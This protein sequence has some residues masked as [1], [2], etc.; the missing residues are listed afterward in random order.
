MEQ[1]VL[2]DK[3]KPFVRNKMKALLGEV[4]DDLA[5]FVIEHLRDHK[6]ADELVDGLEPVRYAECEPAVAYP[7]V[8]AEEAIVFVVALW[9][10][11]IFESTAYKN[12]YETG[13]VMV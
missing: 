12:G 8:F 3:L 9:R 1:T 5:D 11:V 7:Q 4:D 2:N 13:T 10:Q 6:G